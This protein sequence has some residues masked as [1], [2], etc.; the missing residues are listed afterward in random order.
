MGSRGRPRSEPLRRLIGRTLRRLPPRARQRI[1]G[2]YERL[3]RQWV[4][5]FR[6]Y[7]RP[8]LVAALHTLGVSPGDTVMVHSAFRSLSGFDG[9]PS[10]VADAF[11]EAVGPGGNV[12]MVSLPFGGAAIDYLERERRFDVRR[13]PSRMGIVSEFFRRRPGVRRSL[14]PTHPILALGP[15]AEA[16]LAGHEDCPYPCGPCSPF[17]ALVD[18]K[19]KVLFF[20]TDLTTM[21][22]FHWLEH[23]VREDL[24]FPLY[25]PEPFEATVLDREGR[26]RTVRTHAYSREAIRRRRDYILHEEMERRGLV[27]LGRVGNT[28]LLLADA[29]EM[30]DCVEDM[31]HQ[32]IYFFEMP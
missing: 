12:L 4:G 30:A 27:R 29:Q 18:R 8:T 31:A 26:K 16:I 10:D 13:T 23:Q 22:F 7:D 11:L 28:R 3:A 9:Q 21:T 6:S 32:G 1:R 20:D 19:G 15:D 2:A 25:H 17:Q 5:L 24:P 14:H